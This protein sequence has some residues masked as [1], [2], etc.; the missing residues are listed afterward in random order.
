MKNIIG[1]YT[2]PR[3]HWVGDGFPVRTTMTVENSLPPEQ[4]A[5]MAEAQQ[6]MAK[7]QAEAEREMAKAKAE[8]AEQEKKEDGADAKDAG[9]N[10]ASGGGIGGALGGFL[11]KKMNKAASKKAESAAEAQTKEMMGSGPSF[12]GPLFRSVTDVLS[13]SSAPAPAGSFDVPAGYTL[14]ATKH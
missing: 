11:G 10:I 5:Q 7:A 3:T 1:I 14:K 6:E 9:Q 4:Q 12:G 2:S 8:H 13:I